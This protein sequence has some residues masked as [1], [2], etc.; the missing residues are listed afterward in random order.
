MGPSAPP[1]VLSAIISSNYL[2]VYVS[3]VLIRARLRAK[4]DFI[5]KAS[6]IALST[7]TVLHCHR[8]AG[9]RRLSLLSV[10]VQMCRETGTVNDDSVTMWPSQSFSAPKLKG[11]HQWKLRLGESE[12]ICA[13][14]NFQCDL[15][16]FSLL[17]SLWSVSNYVYDTICILKKIAV[18]NLSTIF[19]AIIG[20]NMVHSIILRKQFPQQ[21]SARSQDHEKTTNSHENCFFGKNFIQSQYNLRLFCCS[22][23]HY[24][25]VFYFYHGLV[26]LC[27]EK[28]CFLRIEGFQCLKSC[29]SF[30]VISS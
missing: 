2:S 5:W 30:N 13:T 14:C 12:D 6:H 20:E 25:V 3:S 11:L 27:T 24:S 19:L 18:F 16:W 8:P 23:Q 29:L 1:V 10:A 7:S 22:R 28:L 17:K 15:C 26:R 4:A 21:V 9:W